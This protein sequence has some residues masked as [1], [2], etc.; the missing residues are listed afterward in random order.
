MEG[1]GKK[2]LEES[3]KGE[4]VVKLPYMVFIFAGNLM[5]K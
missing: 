4:K 3:G 5:L 2:G 1:P